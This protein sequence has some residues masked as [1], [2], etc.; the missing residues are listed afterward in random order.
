M[1]CQSVYALYSL[2]SLYNS[3]DITR[4]YSYREHSVGIL[5]N[6]DFSLSLS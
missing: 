5:A 3:V 2:I 6:V 4:Y 1:I